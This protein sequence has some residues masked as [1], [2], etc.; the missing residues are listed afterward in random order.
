VN[1]D[2]S[3]FIT[4]KIDEL[5]RKKSYAIK[6]K[7]DVRELLASKAEGTFLWISLVLAVL[8]NT[9]KHKVKEKLNALP[10]GLDA[11]YDRILQ[12]FEEAEDARFILQCVVVARRPLAVHEIATAYAIKLGGWRKD[13][14]PLQGDL[15]EYTNVF[16]NMQANP[17]FR[18]YDIDS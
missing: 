9:P 11:I 1:A 7:D 4:I 3:K 13:A 14:A 6:L 10:A 5:A 8:G 16:E 15:E 2:L 17:L 12:Q 18:R